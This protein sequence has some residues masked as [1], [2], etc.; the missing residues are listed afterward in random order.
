MPRSRRETIVRARSHI[1]TIHNCRLTERVG[2]WPGQVLIAV[3]ATC[4][5]DIALQPFPTAVHGVASI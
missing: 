3:E 5:A 2:H 4:T 1:V